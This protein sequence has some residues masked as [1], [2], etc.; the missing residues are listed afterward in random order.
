MVIDPAGGRIEVPFW[1]LSTPSPTRR[2][3]IALQ[4]AVFVALQV[5]LYAIVGAATPTHPRDLIREAVSRRASWL[6][7]QEDAKNQIAQKANK[8]EYLSQRHKMPSQQTAPQDKQALE[9]F[10]SATQGDKWVNNAG[11]MKGDPCQDYWHGL[12]CSESG[13]VLQMTLVFNQLSGYIPSDITRMDKLQVLRLYSNDIGGSIPA[14]LFI[15][16]DLQELDLNNNQLTGELPGTVSMPNVT[17]LNLYTNAIEGTIPTTWETPEAVTLSLSSNKLYGPMPPSIGKLTKLQELFLS[18]NLL[19]GDL[20]VEYGQLNKLSTLWL[21]DNKFKNSKIPQSWSGMRSL[22]NVQLTGLGGELPAWVGDSWSELLLLT[23]AN[24]DLTGSF[25]ES[26]CSLQKV[27]YLQLYNNSLSGKLPSCICS[28]PPSLVSLELSDNQLTGEIPDCLGKLVNLTY[29]YVSRN[30][31]SG[32]LPKSLGS[33]TYLNVLDVS[34][35][36]LT[37]AVP[38][39]YAG[40]KD[41][42]YQFALCYNKLSS[43]EN[44]LQELL[45]HVAQYSCLLYENPWTCPLPSYIP[46]ECGAVCSKCNS[47][48]QH[49]SCTSCVKDSSCGWCNEGPSC[50]EGSKD[51]PDSEYKCETSDW[52]YGEQR[53]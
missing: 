27:Q 25:P 36:A 48:S 13:R 11:W 17:I 18:N 39:A 45:N 41:G 10:Y 33:L 31:L 43:F 46:K 34:S 19:S 44:G 15:M 21:F 49:T 53:C 8:V 50:L 26:L 35:N 14:G 37:G 23:I 4:L 47:G 7:Q 22:Q 1:I 51:G 28:L 29:F 16:Q 38:S 42:T 32:N 24:G 12:Y 5:T 6:Q 40:L 20:P 2:M 3:K 30:N 52:F 9:S